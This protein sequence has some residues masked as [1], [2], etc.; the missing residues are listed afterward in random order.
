MRV[1]NQGF[2]KNAVG[3][4]Q[5]L[6]RELNAVQ[7]QIATGRRIQRP[8][9]DPN[10]ASRILDYRESLATLEQYQRN[11]E[12]ARNRLRLSED[13]L[14][15]VTSELQRIRELTLQAAN[16]SQTNETRGFIATELSESVEA[17]LGL[18]NTRD[19][20]D[21]FLFSGFQSGTQ[22]FSRTPGG[23]SYNG[24]D[25][26]RFIQVSTS[27]KIPDTN[28]GDEIF[29]RIREGNGQ[30]LVSPSGANTGTGVAVNEVQTRV[31]GYDFA[32]FDVVFL[33]AE[34]YEVRDSL[35]AVVSSGTFASGDSIA[36]GPARVRI[37]G[38]PAAGDMFSVGPAPNRDVFSIVDEIAQALATDSNDA[39]TR[40]ELNSAVNRGLEGIDRAL[41]RVLE[42][43]T[44][45]GSRLAA[46]ESQLDTNL[47]TE[48]VL[49]EALAG[50]ED[51]DLA[52]AASRLAAQ[53]SALEAAQ[54]SFIR[55]Q[56]LSLFNFL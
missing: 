18:A 56:S 19:A 5:D 12:L 23:F 52:E 53:A 55:V 27:R 15:Q 25:G 20:S 21:Q 26:Q 8:S 6:Q 24:D 49:Q 41:E 35:G 39:T 42:I 46:A 43:R 45:I 37:D 16:A 9:D 14:T 28:S 7:E 40:A 54:Q 50:V 22:P 17:L 31:Q 1:T 29:A 48:L 11:T 44:S 2:F 10:G 4:I 3:N 38:Q 36:A 30:V 32:T 33:D 47:G 13:T 34:N 51:L